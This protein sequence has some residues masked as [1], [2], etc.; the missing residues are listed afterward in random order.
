MEEKTLGSKWGEMKKQDL[1]PELES[2]LTILQLRKFMNPKSFFKNSE[3]KN[4]PKYFQIGTIVDGGDDFVGG[5]LKKKEKRNNLIDLFL[6]DDKDLQFSRKR[7]LEIQKDKQKRSRNRSNSK[8][9]KLKKFGKRI[10][11]K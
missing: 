9:R 10:K 5:R 11:R 2:D 1:N 4:L 7:F 8:F 6:K 3:N